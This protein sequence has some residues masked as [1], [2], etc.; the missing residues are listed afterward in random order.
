MPP[1]KS[2]EA[3]MPTAKARILSRAGSKTG[4]FPR[5]LPS[6]WRSPSRPCR[7]S[8]PASARTRPV[9]SPRCTRRCPCAA[10]CTPKR[11]PSFQPATTGSSPRH[12][13]TP[14][15]SAPL[16]ARSTGSTSFAWTTPVTANPSRSRWS[17]T[18]SW[19]GPHAGTWSPST[20]MRTDG[21][22]CAWTASNHTCPR[23][24]P[25][26]DVTSR[27]AIPPPLV[28]TAHDRGDAAAEWPC[29]G[30]AIVALPA[31]TVARFP[32]ADQQSGTSP[33]PR[34]DSPLGAWS[35]PGL[36]GLLLT[37]DADITDIEPAELRQALHSLRTRIIKELRPD[38]PHR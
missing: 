32:P 13:S 2:T 12:R 28:M 17:R 35:W 27:T 15:S 31:S 22:R 11:S 8:S 6:P 26:T 18:I 5:P 33:K 10:A 9:L 21:A 7:R 30:S 23:T 14:R 24:P 19:S 36:A 37:F 1:K 16:A 38:R 3:L 29:R 25:S 20:R 34:A 4:S